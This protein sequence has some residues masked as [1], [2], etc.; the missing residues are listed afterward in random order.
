MPLPA[1]APFG[2]L[3]IDAAGCTLCLACVGACPTGA[4]IDNPERPMLRFLED[5]CVQC[6]LCQNTCPENVIRLEPRLNFTAA[7]RSPRTIKEEEPALCLRCGKAFGTKSSI[8]RI[9]ARL[10]GRNPLFETPE[11]V[12]RIRMCEDCRVVS[13]FEAKDNPFRLGQARSRGRARTICGSAPRRPGATRM[14]RPAVPS[15]VAAVPC[16]H[17]PGGWPLTAVPSPSSTVRMF[18]ATRSRARPR[19]RRAACRVVPPAAGRRP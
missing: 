12:E 1:G 4:L 6:G 19:S 10:A 8:E 17:C 9:V 11:Q 15:A 3:Q 13:Q 14:S 5:A 7:A 18:A 16:R 2:N